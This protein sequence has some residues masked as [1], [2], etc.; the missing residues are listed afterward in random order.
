M[1]PEQERTAKWVEWYK[2]VLEGRPMDTPTEKW[3]KELRE[4]GKK[5]IP[6]EEQ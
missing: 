6:K 2:A 5:E 1:T 3:L 4:K